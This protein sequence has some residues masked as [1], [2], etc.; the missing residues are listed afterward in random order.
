MVARSM[1]L[2]QNKGYILCYHM[3]VD[4]PNGF[5]PQTSLQ[6]FTRQIEYLSRHCSVIPL[7]EMVERLTKSKSVRG[8]VAITFDDGF[9]D[10]YAIAYPVLMK[11]NLPSTIFLTTG[12]IETG[13]MPWFIRLR[14]FFMHFPYN[15]MSIDLGA[16]HIEFS[17]TS[18]HEKRAASDVVMEYLQ[19]CRDED[20]LQLLQRLPLD[21]SDLSLTRTERY[22]LNWQEIREMSRNGVTFGVHTVTHPVLSCVSEPVF[23]YEIGVSRKTIEE[24]TGQP[25]DVFAYPFGRKEHYPPYAP[26]VLKE[27]GFKCALTTEPGGNTCRVNI[28]ELKRSSPRDLLLI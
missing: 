23:R 5:F 11:Y 8:C 12:Y 27:L 25:A 14:S 16:R 6:D 3:I 15:R 18:P 9:R 13:E 1:R 2:L 21:L 24:R 28:Y 19:S 17:M 10:N 22:M 7:Y 26:M 4:R 20:R